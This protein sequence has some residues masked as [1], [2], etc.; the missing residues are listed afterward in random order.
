MCTYVHSNIIHNNTKSEESKF[1]SAN[2][3]INK[4]GH[5]HTR[6]YNSTIREWSTDSCYNV[7]E[8]WNCYMTELNKPD[9]GSTHCIILFT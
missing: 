9:S 5:I 4:T 6:K 7:D 8:P 1:S 2:E 3:W